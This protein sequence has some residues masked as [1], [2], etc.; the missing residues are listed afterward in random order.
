ML[1][2][3]VIVIAAALS[4]TNNVVG[5]SF[6]M[7]LNDPKLLGAARSR[8]RVWNLG[9]M[10]Q[11]TLLNCVAITYVFNRLGWWQA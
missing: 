3:I 10:A 9:V 2:V 7:L 5:W 8:S 6:Y 11:V 4:L 1:L